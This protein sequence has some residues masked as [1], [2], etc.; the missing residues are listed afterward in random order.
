MSNQ[1]FNIESLCKEVGQERSS[2]SKIT[3]DCN[4]QM[5]CIYSAWARGNMESIWQG[6]LGPNFKYYQKLNIYIALKWWQHKKLA[7]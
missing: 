7:T 4:G 3:V 2:G 5:S 1:L 6:T